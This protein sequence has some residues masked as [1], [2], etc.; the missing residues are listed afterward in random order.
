[1]PDLGWNESAPPTT[2]SAGLGAQQFQSLKTA[3]RTGLDA[4]HAWPTSGLGAGTHR[5]G[6]ARA[7]Y[8]VQS[9]VS[10]TGTDGRLHVTSDSSRLFHVGSAGTMFLGGS[11]VISAGSQP[12][13]GQRFY[14]AQEF[15]NALTGG[16]G[17]VTVTIPN[18]GYSGVPF[19]VATPSFLG[20]STANVVAIN[21]QTKSAVGF[22]VWARYPDNSSAAGVSVDWCSIGTRIF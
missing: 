8:G 6:S 19:V 13:G 7:Y 5:L 21:I 12:V 11:A 4:E 17:Q 15:G 3:I 2:E 10:S 9:L 16:V 22:T 14:W 20:G 18:S 1:M